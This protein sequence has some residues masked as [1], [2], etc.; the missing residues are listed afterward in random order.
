MGA[1]SQ[2]LS[3]NLRFMKKYEN[4]RSLFSKL[5]VSKVN[6]QLSLLL[7]EKGKLDIASL[8]KNY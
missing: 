7:D 4:T 6:K 5:I 2:V 8:Q 1:V 3:K